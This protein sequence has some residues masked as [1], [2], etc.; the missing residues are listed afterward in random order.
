MSLIIE[1]NLE[2]CRHFQQWDSLE[3]K[4]KAQFYDLP[5]GSLRPKKIIFFSTDLSYK[6]GHGSVIFMPH[7][8][9]IKAEL[10][11]FVMENAFI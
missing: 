7:K 4:H 2:K 3:G 6:A 5:M 1:V 10:L 8:S 9:S 11:K